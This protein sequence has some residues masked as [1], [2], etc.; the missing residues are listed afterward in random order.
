VSSSENI[1]VS[2][3][4]EKKTA[5]MLRDEVSS[6]FEKRTAQRRPA[7]SGRQGWPGFMARAEPI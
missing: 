5:R 1:T 7:S 4:A 3:S 2:F 6:V